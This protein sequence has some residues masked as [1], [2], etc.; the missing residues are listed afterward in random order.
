MPAADASAA[1]YPFDARRRAERHGAEAPRR[2]H[3][4]RDRS[5]ATPVLPRGHTH[6]SVR[7]HAGSLAP[8]PGDNCKEHGKHRAHSCRGVCGGVVGPWDGPLGGE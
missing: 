6:P 2:S 7:A 8:P 5:D 1:F 3:E 4:G